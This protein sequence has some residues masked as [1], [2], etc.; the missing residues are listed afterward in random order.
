MD[1]PS[2]AID[3]T[4]N[5]ERYTEI[6]DKLTP[7]LKTC[8]YNPKTDIAF[9]PI[10]ALHGHNVVRPLRTLLTLSVTPHWSADT[11][12]VCPI[13][14]LH[15]HMAAQPQRGT[16]DSPDIVFFKISCTYF[17]GCSLSSLSLLCPIVAPHGHTAA[18][19][20]TGDSPYIRF[21]KISGTYFLW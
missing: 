16:G 6:V 11:S 2:V 8:G 12:L 4:W 21:V 3:G 13:A 9:C 1:D 5:K 17:S 19:R 20:G 15:G 18:L 14:A 10:A 7:F